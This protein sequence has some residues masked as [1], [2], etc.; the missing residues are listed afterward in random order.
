MCFEKDFVGK[1][2]ARNCEMVWTTENSEAI[3]LTKDG[4]LVAGVWYED[5]SKKS[6]TCHIAIT[7]R[8][9]RQYLGII[10]DYPFVQLGVEKIICPVL[11][12]ND[13]SIRLV[14]N[15]GFE[16]QARLLDVSP[17]GDMLFFVMSKDKCR[18]LGER[19]GQKN[20][21]SCSP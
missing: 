2:V 8:I 7:G 14:K 15:M 21:D 16:E 5:Y 11:S 13:K 1:Y 17:S 3:G 20:S 10:F 19:Y 9:T 12:D 4:E 18:F 6:I